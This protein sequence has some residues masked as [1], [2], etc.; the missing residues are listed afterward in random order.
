MTTN[1]EKELD[2]IYCEYCD[3]DTRHNPISFCEGH[4]RI[5]DEKIKQ[6]ER[7][8]MLKEFKI[9][10]D[11]IQERIYQW[12]KDK[13]GNVFMSGIIIKMKCDVE[14]ALREGK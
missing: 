4:L 13:P 14:R 11:E 3:P 7:Q 5:R 1:D 12:R 2:D 6:E 8:R 9:I 10:Y